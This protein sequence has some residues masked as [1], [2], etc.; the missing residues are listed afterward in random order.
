MRIGV[1]S[2]PIT[3]VGMSF[4]S[5][6]ART[7]AKSRKTFRT[8]SINPQVLEDEPLLNYFGGIFAGDGCLV[9][10]RESQSIE[11]FVCG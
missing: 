9:M 4:T 8:A 2:T 10:Q 11:W 6:Q 1:D 3:L 7:A 5:E